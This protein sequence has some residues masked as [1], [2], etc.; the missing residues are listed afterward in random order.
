M[1][2]NLENQRCLLNKR[3]R[4]KSIKK[5]Q[6]QQEKKRTR[7]DVWTAVSSQ[8]VSVSQWWA[9][10]A[11]KSSRKPSVHFHS[12]F[13]Q[14]QCCDSLLGQRDYWDQ[15]S[16]SS[17]PLAQSAQPAQSVPQAPRCLTEQPTR[18]TESK[19]APGTLLIVNALGGSLASQHEEGPQSQ[20]CP[21]APCSALT[22]TF[23]GWYICSEALHFLRA[24]S[25][26]NWYLRISQL[27]T[28]SAPV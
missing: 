16:P 20:S 26:K 15:A 13:Q 21:N 2:L 10:L 9:P 25:E 14:C 24:S 18:R 12:S 23:W 17:M 8:Y 6:Q 19:E 1:Y 22:Q 28:Q 3:H 11:G 5:P 7:L 4:S 27:S